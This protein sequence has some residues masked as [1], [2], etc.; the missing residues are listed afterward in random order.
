MKKIFF[1]FFIF[2]FSFLA[3]HCQEI[4]K[5]NKLVDP[6]FIDSTT[7]SFVVRYFKNGVVEVEYTAINDYV[8]R[9]MITITS[10][11]RTLDVYFTGIMKKG[12]KY[13][14]IVQVY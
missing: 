10:G 3:S 9:V 11:T 14:K 13:S 5:P 2:F 1:L 6:I 8:G 7:K 4:L 12:Q